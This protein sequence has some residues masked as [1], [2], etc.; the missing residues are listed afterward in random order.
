MFFIHSNFMHMPVY[1]RA[2]VGHK[3]EDLFEGMRVGRHISATFKVTPVMG[4]WRIQQAACGG[5]AYL[6]F[7]IKL[8]R[9]SLRNDMLREAVYVHGPTDSCVTHSLTPALPVTLTNVCTPW[10]CLAAAGATPLRGVGL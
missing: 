3:L 9:Q 2:Q 1:A 5:F 10:K 6:R 7:R 8:Q 4:A